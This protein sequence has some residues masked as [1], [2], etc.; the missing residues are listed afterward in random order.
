MSPVRRLLDWCLLWL[1]SA[2]LDVAVFIL[3]RRKTSSRAC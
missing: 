1:C 3:K 2:A